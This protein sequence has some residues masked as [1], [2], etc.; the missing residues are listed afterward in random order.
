[1]IADNGVSTSLTLAGSG[2]TN[3]EAANTYSGTTYFVN[4]ILD[5]SNTAALA[6]STLNYEG[7]TVNF[8]GATSYSF[9]GLS[10]SYPTAQ[11]NIQALTLSVGG[12]NQNTTYAGALIGPGGALTKVGTGT[13]TLTGSSS[14]N[15]QTLIS[16]G[17]LTLASTNALASS[18][19]V[20]N[21]GQL[22]FG[23]ISTTLLGGLSGSQSVTLVNSLSAP[24]TLSVGGNGQST[25][26]S[27]VLSDNGLGGGLNVTGGAITLTGSNT[28]SGNTNLSAGTLT[29]GNPS[30]IADSTLN[31]VGGHLNVRA[32]TAITVGGLSGSSHF[33]CK[34][35]VP[36]PSPS[37]WQATTKPST[38]GH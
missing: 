12:N 7:G 20:C 19:V 24:V 13:L 8:L 23:P 37:R 4:G 18:T 3:L 14:Y 1:M 2:I 33:P 5:L 31:L 34:T 30:A 38:A 15:G 36:R 28:Y 29:L 9:G 6:G 22:S 32:N 35:P 11:L 27:G 10:G 26:Y 21:G 17:N 16:A 25:T